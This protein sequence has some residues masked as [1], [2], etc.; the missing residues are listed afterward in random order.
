MLCQEVLDRV[1]LLIILTDVVIT[2]TA[3]LSSSKSPASRAYPELS[4]RSPGHRASDKGEGINGDVFFLTL[5][6]AITILTQ[7]IRLLGRYGLFSRKSCT[8]NEMRKKR[9]RSIIWS[10]KILQNPEDIVG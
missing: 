5:T 7:L 8:K 1:F 3:E 9:S 6:F 10:R 2:I 4:S